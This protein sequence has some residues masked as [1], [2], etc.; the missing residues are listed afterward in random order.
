MTATEKRY[1]DAGMKAPAHDR[2]VTETIHSVDPE[3]QPVEDVQPAKPT[4]ASTTSK[5]ES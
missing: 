4:K 2:R 3:T 1:T 5:K